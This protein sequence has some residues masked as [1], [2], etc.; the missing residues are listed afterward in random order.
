MCVCVCVSAE[1]REFPEN[2]Y[3]WFLKESE[4]AEAIL[5]PGLGRSEGQ[6]HDSSGMLRGSS[7]LPP[8]TTLIHSIFTRVRPAHSSPKLHVT[9]FRYTLSVRLSVCVPHDCP[10]V[11]LQ[12]RSHPGH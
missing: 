8:A 11:T 6:V 9:L 3:Q 10:T 4:G 12:C 5:G 1:Q 2:L 7:S